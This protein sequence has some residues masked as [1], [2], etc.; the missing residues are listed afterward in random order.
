MPMPF[1]ACRC[2]PVAPMRV[3]T[4]S[5]CHRQNI[6]S[7]TAAPPIRVMAKPR[8]ASVSARQTPA[9]ASG[10]AVSTRADA[11]AHEKRLRPPGRHGPER[12]RSI[13]RSRGFE[14]RM[15]SMSARQTPTSDLK[16]AISARADARSH[17]KPQLPP[18]RRELTAAPASPIFRGFEAA[19]GKQEREINACVRFRMRKL[20]AA[21]LSSV[22]QQDRLA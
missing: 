7:V 8:M 22:Y 19:R 11:R 13:A 3:S 20:Y 14:T 21:L 6:T 17:E 5:A 2:R 9:I 10:C 16:C 1:V 12:S 18:R 15:A 4:N